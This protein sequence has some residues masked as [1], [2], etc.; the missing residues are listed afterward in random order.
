MKYKNHPYPALNKWI[1]VIVP[2]FFL[3]TGCATTPEKNT[4]L[5]HARSVVSQVQA[6]PD[7]EQYAKVEAYE[8]AQ[9]LQKAEN[10]KDPETMEHYA[11]IAEKDAQIAE[12]RAQ[13]KKADKEMEDLNKEKE[14]IQLEAREYELAKA[15]KEVEEKTREAMLNEQEAR[16]K[17]QEA[18]ASEQEAKRKTQEALASE[19]EAKRQA[20]EASAMAHEAEMARMQAQ[21]ES[22]QRQQLESELAELKAK[23]TERGLVVTLGDILFETGKARL[24]AGTMLTIDKLADVLKKYPTRNVLI[25]GHTDSRGG[26]TYNLH[27]SEQ[28]AEAVRSA[29][30]ERGIT[31]D[32]ITTKGYGKMY[33]IASNSNEAGRQQNRRVEIVILDEGE[34]PEKALR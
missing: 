34:S 32:R 20:Q 21:Q 14:K 27:L 10:A 24:L 6:D 3:T 30:I 12:N 17:T 29:L 25:E 31:A 18:L 7:V 33:P 26:E 9:A 16:Q 1:S 11:Y 19:Q 15:R 5:D 23:K 22:A 13:E 8:A 28:R 4:A 2:V